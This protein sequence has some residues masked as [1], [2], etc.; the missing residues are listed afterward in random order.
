MKLRL[1]L[2]GIR[3]GAPHEAWLRLHVIR[4]YTQIKGVPTSPRVLV[5][6]CVEDRGWGDVDATIHFRRR[7]EG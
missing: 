6:E 7:E 5:K 3:G 2:G 4:Y 1:W